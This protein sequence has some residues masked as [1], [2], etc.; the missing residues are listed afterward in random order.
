MCIHTPV[1]FT[2]SVLLANDTA[3]MIKNDVLDF[4]SPKTTQWYV[5]KG[6]PYRR[7]YLL[8]GPPGCGKT[9]FIQAL[10]GVWKSVCM[11]VCVLC[12]Y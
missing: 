1:Y 10:A 3:A 12:T 4:L 6:I 5:D 11:C 2:H 9:S 7:G 8:H